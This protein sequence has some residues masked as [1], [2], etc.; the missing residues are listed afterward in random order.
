MTAPHV[1][2]V[3][4]VLADTYIRCESSPTFRKREGTFFRLSR[5]GAYPVTVL[6]GYRIPAIYHRHR[7]MGFRFTV[8]LFRACTFA[9]NHDC[10]VYI[11]VYMYVLCIPVTCHMPFHGTEC[12]CFPRLFIHSISISISHLVIV[13][14]RRRIHGYSSSSSDRSRKSIPNDSFFFL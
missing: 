13:A 2:V 8:L 12:L 6:C 1:L 9:E 4:Y 5:L 11:Y 14:S 10:T 3:S 7:P